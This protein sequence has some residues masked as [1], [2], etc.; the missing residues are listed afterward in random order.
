[1]ENVKVTYSTSRVWERHQK[2]RLWSVY[3]RNQRTFDGHID[4]LGRIGTVVLSKLFRCKCV[5]F[6]GPG[7]MGGSIHTGSV[8][9]LVPI[10]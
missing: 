8:S 6:W 5:V 10:P 7:L 1:M 4:G 9:Y 2:Q 3:M